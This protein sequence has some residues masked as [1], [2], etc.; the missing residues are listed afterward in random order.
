M[1]RI[2]FITSRFPF[3]AEKGD[4]LRAYFQILDLA[5]NHELHVISIN[6]TDISESQRAALSNCAS[7]SVF[8]ISKMKRI[9]SLFKAFFTKIPFQ[10]GY[11]FD[12]RI[13]QKVEQKIREI[14]PEFIHCHLIR[15]SEYVK[16]LHGISK[17][18]DFMDAFSLGMEKRRGITENILKRWVFGLESSRL[19]MYET[20]MFSVFDS[21]CV[22][23]DQDRNELIGNGTKTF[24][25]VPNGVDFSVF[26]PKE[27]SKKYDL[28]FM[29]NIAYPPNAEAVRFLVEKIFPA[30]LL[31]RP[32]TSL[33]I[34]GANPPEFIRGY[35][36][37]NITVQSYFEDISDAIAES[38][39]LI[40]P[41]II[42]IGLANKII[43]SMAMKVPNIVSVNAAK[44]IEAKDGGEL[45]IADSIAEYVTKIFRL[46]NDPEMYEMLSENAFHFV[47]E[48]YNWE[49]V[50][51]KLE[52][53][54]VGEYQNKNN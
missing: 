32:N 4:Q 34:A 40:S 9:F 25:V 46:L 27:T 51:N 26:F 49:V 23:S 22:I 53:V 13:K 45:L 31:I 54:I 37:K 5:R 44:A 18:L 43:Q 20:Q 29:G 16:D 47:K 38:R 14:R 50:N 19:K 3:P 39:V 7:V 10:I 24:E 15:C 28:C 35:A 17:S 2:V 21:F 1:A 8:Q 42:S 33:L 11:F 41:L 12:S 52:K 30:L 36:G 48:Q 6:E